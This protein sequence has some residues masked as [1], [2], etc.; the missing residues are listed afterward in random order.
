MRSFLED[1]QAFDTR[2]A[3]ALL[4]TILQAAHTYRDGRIE[5]EFRSYGQPEGPQF[6]CLQPPRTPTLCYAAMSVL[7]VGFPHGWLARTESR[8]NP[9]A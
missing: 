9:A 5:L 4:Q 6:P 7:G 8:R 2:R 1:V 3:K